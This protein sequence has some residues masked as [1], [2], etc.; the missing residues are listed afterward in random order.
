[1]CVKIPHSLQQ[2]YKK[3]NALLFIQTFS[4]G[5]RTVFE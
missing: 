1:M 2:Q 4:E 3:E 5:G